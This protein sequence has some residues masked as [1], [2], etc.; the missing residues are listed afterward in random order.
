[1][2]VFFLTPY[3]IPIPVCKHRQTWESCP[4]NGGGTSHGW[5]GYTPLKPHPLWASG[6]FR[7]RALSSFTHRAQTW[8]TFSILH[9]HVLL[10]LLLFLISSS[11][12]FLK[13]EALP[14]WHL[15][16]SRS[17]A[18]YSQH[19]EYPHRDANHSASTNLSQE[20]LLRDWDHWVFALS[21]L[22]VTAFSLGSV[23]WI[24]HL[25]LLE[26]THFISTGSFN[27]GLQ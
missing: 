23:C 6:V 14:S 22:T 18:H 5:W 13:E 25:F 19:P 3:H 8:P 20:N 26:I 9:F 1:M 15:P 2:Q 10:R 4:C 27:K 21:I 17:F 11:L 12:F 7:G 24:F 16:P